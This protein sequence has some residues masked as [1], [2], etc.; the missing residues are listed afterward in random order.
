MNRHKNLKVR[1]LDSYGKKT[2]D[3]LRLSVVQ[4]FSPLSLRLSMCKRQLTPGCKNMN[5]FIQ[6]IIIVFIVVLTACSQFEERTAVDFS[7]RISIDKPVSVESSRGSIRIAIGAMVSPK[8][9]FSAYQ[10][11]VGYLSGKLDRKIEIVQRK[12]YQEINEMLAEGAVDLAFICSGPYVTGK[13]KHGL[14]LLVAPEVNGSHFYNSYLIVNS[15][16]PEKTI[17][18]LR[19]KTFAFTDPDSNTGRLSPT[20]MLREIGETPETF[21]G[22]I[23]YT[24]SHDNSILAVSKGLVQGASVDGL[25]WDYFNRINPEITSSTRII[26]KSEDYG[27]PPVVV[28]SAMDEK[29]RASIK[30]AFLEMASDPEG[31]LILKKLMIERFVE[32]SDSWYDSIRVIV[33]SKPSV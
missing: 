31:A 12:T 16:G 13:E 23:I 33:G 28:S 1:K 5:K 27:I 6:L 11:L 8:E 10:D 30:K 26:A 21:F 32:A 25:I 20:Y 22:S 19:G 18:D 7:K 29:A 4:A 24:Y 9:T 2:N 3:S 17:N 15:S 14:E